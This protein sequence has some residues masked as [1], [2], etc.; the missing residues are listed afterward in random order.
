MPRRD[1]FA[2]SSGG[3]AMAGQPSDDRVPLS[4]AITLQRGFDLPSHSREEGV[5]PVV[6][7]AGIVGTHSV[8]KVDAPGVVIGRSGS[9]GGGQW[10]DT[11]FWPLNTTLWVKDFK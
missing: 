8:A 11:P 2:N 4:D 7:S 5:I 3:S 10:L 1:L 9:I 6:A